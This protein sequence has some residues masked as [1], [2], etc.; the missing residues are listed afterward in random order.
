MTENNFLKHNSQSYNQEG[1]GEVLLFIHGFCGSAHYWDELIPLLKDDYTVLCVN[2]RGHGGNKTDDSA[3]E[4]TDMARDLYHFLSQHSVDQVY[5]FGHSLGGYISL[6]FAELFPSKL[7][8]F[9]LIHSTAFPD[10]DNAKEAR[11]ESMNLIDERGLA[12]FV[13]R[14]IPNL[15]SKDSLAQLK[16]KVSK[17]KEIGYGTDVN[18]AKGALMAMRNRPDR[19][20]VLRET[21]KPVLL[22]AGEK[23]KVIP[24]EKVFSVEDSHIKT[25]LLPK[26]GHMGMLETPEE[27]ARIIKNWIKLSKLKH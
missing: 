26:A 27:L 12:S 25:E 21:S 22:V 18:G 23:D 16:D 8:G 19:N 7:K 4:I 20:H 5:M 3:I 1:K 10:S 13:D 2:L 6:A 14:L 11:I 24:P 9:G 17:V 15:F